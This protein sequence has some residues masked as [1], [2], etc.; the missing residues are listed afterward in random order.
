MDNVKETTSQEIRIDKISCFK[1]GRCNCT[2]RNSCR[3]SQDLTE[4]IDILIRRACA[5]AVT[6]DEII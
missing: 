1:K 5:L 4:E 3:E 6:M 2:F